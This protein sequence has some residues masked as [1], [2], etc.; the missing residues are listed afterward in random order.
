MH[1]KVTAWH[2]S[3]TPHEG[4]SPQDPEVFNTV[5][6]TPAAPPQQANPREQVGGGNAFYDLKSLTPSLSY[7]L[8]IRSESL[9]LAHFQG[10]RN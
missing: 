3:V 8:F 9:S 6:P 7:I 4:L 1:F 10:E 5:D 2:G